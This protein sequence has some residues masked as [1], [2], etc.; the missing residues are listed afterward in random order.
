M[1]LEI[2]V[3]QQILNKDIIE[4]NNSM[5]EKQSN[6]WSI[7]SGPWSM[8]LREYVKSFPIV[9]AIYD[10]EKLVHEEKIDYGNYEHRKWLGRATFWACNQGYVVETSKA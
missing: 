8:P 1:N 10:G 4:E 2:S 9:V 3:G 5:N 6:R 7:Q